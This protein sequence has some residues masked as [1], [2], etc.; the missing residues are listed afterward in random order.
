MIGFLINLLIGI[1]G[2]LLAERLLASAA[3]RDPAKFILVLII[4]IVVFFLNIAQYAI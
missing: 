3:V 1:L 2:Y 4:G